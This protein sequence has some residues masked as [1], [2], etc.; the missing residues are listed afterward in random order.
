VGFVGAAEAG[1]LRDEVYGLHRVEV[2]ERRFLRFGT[3][4]SQS[5]LEADDTAGEGLVAIDSGE[6]LRRLRVQTLLLAQLPY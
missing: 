6:A 5:P 1:K 2:T 3:A 4:G